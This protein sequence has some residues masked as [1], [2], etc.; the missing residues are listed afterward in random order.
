MFN[1]YWLSDPGDKEGIDRALVPALEC[2]TDR[3]VRA[4]SEILAERLTRTD[5]R[6][7]LAD[8]LERADPLAYCL[9]SASCGHGM[10]ARWAG[11]LRTS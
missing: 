6:I 9:D 1:R 10:P 7:V 8:L 3:N 2:V 5:S 11:V 4:G